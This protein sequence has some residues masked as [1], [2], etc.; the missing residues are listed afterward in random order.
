MKLT[1]PDGDAILRTIEGDRVALDAS[2]PAAPGTPL[3][4]SLDDGSALRIKVQ[5]CVRDGERFA[6]DGRLLD[7]SRALRQKLEEG[8]QRK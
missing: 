6:I 3:R 2:V 8:L 7:A 1:L 5:R 4:A